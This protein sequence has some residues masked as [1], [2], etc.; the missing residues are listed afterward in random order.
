MGE[1]L[2]GETVGFHRGASPASEARE[3]GRHAP[4]GLG[5]NKRVA[6]LTPASGGVEL[7]LVIHRWLYG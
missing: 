3:R 1:P 4:C 7:M 2:A 6:R 5:V